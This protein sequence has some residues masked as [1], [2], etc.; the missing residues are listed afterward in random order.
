MADTI[1][2]KIIAKTVP[3]HIVYEDAEV[4][5]F[6]D[7]APL[8]P[9][10]VLVVPKEPAE[11]LDM[12]SETSAAAVGRVLP[13]LCRAVMQATGAEAYNVLQNNRPL[14]H[15]AVMH[16]HFHIIP[17][18]AATQGLGL[19]WQPIPWPETNRLEMAAQ[20]KAHLPAT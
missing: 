14:A 6:L 13:K 5:A 16:V 17:K 1:F 4:I 2:K 18:A 3:A 15:Q 7:V 9:G 20:I 12:L 11:T 10:H 19:A 8:S